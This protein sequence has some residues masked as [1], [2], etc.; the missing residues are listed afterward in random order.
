[1]T[2]LAR[3][4]AVIETA[5]GLTA[6][7]DPDWMIWGPVGGYVAAIALRAAAIKAPVGHRPVTLSCQFIGRGAEGPT[8][9]EVD[10][11]RSGSTSLFDVRLSQGS[12]PF[13]TA[14][15][16]TTA[17]TQ[18]PSAQ[19]VAMPDVP[20][21]DTL[22]PFTGQLARFGHQPI[23]FWINVD[24]RQVNFLAPGDPDSRG[25]RTERW[26]RFADWDT[27]PDPF[28]D[29][30]RAVIGIDVHFWAAH[31]RGLNAV[32]T[33]VAPSLDLTV[34][35]H[36]AVPEDEWQLVEARADIAGEGLL[37]G[38]ARVWSR[39]GQLVASGGGQCLIVP[40]A[41]GK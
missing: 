20:A 23:P 12:K 9:I 15:I 11:V 25:G 3:A 39:S 21:P 33:Y 24:G 17:K 16:W 31:N 19:H 7:I 37:A 34:W 14:Q 40:L 26:L 8:K 5:D 10:Q 28:L 38:S 36:G 41:Q 2:R 1:M 27:T 32:P 35:F 30:A 22:E 6:N 4:S 13:L 29:A 18:G